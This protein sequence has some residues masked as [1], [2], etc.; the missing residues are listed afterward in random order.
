MKDE[1]RHKKKRIDT[2]KK[3]FDR[4]MSAAVTNTSQIRIENEAS[5]KEKEKTHVQSKCNW[6]R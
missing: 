4:Q 2:E 6:Q 3:K 1:K 5:E